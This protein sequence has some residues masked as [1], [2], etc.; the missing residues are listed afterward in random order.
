MGDRSQPF[1]CLQRVKTWTTKQIGI[2]ER[3][4]RAACGHSQPFACLQWEKAC[5][6]NSTHLD[7]TPCYLEPHSAEEL[8]SLGMYSL[9]QIGLVRL[10]KYYSSTLSIHTCP[11]SFFS[12]FFSH[13]FPFIFSSYFH[14]WSEYHFVIFAISTYLNMPKVLQLA[15]CDQFQFSTV[16]MKFLVLGRPWPFIYLSCLNISPTGLKQLRLSQHIEFQWLFTSS[17]STVL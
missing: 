9:L 5:T 2:R 3:G 14:F 11:S 17:S 7:Q 4:A 13:T 6:A 12:P 8:R 1:T 10:G 16:G 15:E